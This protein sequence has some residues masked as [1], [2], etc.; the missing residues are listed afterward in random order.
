MAFIIGAVSQKGGVGK[1]SIAR[2][3]AGEFAKSEWTVKIAD[4]DTRQGT[5]HDWQKTRIQNRY[6]PDIAVEMFSSVDKALTESDRYD[7]MI[8]DGAPKSSR[9]TLE[10]A[11]RSNLIILP[12]GTGVD[13]LTPTIKLAH[14]LKGKGILSSKM[15]FVLWRTV[16]SQNEIDAAR[17][18]IEENGYYVLKGWVPTKTGYLM[19]QDKGL[20]AAET[21]F[22]SLNKKALDIVKEINDRIENGD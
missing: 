10:I 12:T 13:D 4:I 3:V 22:P 8:L 18:N 7:M 15:I 14:E 20:T 16:E 21:P 19:A 9:D 1:S 2:L 17:E 11:K 6:E 5:V